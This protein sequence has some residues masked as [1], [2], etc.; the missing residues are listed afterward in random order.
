MIS[1]LPITRTELALKCES[2]VR[3]RTKW[4]RI[5]KSLNRDVIDVFGLKITKDAVAQ[6]G[7]LKDGEFDYLKFNDIK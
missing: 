2:W 7:F 3:D 5:T 1:T 6:A 4:D